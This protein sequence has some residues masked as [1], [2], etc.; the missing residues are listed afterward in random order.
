[1]DALKPRSTF[2]LFHTSTPD[3]FAACA[4][5]GALMTVWHQAADL[6]KAQPPGTWADLE[7]QWLVMA[8][9]NDQLFLFC[10]PDL[11]CLADGSDCYLYR[12]EDHEF[13]DPGDFDALREVVA[14]WLLNP[15]FVAGAASP[16]QL[17]ATVRYNYGD[18]NKVEHPA[19]WVWNGNDPAIP[20]GRSA[21]ASPTA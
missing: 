15:V 5:Y 11:D 16:E 1:M 19:S 2:P 21:D 18:T 20:S 4:Q 9:M 14:Q 6:F 8:P 17:Q 7:G 13:G 3:I 10:S 12:P